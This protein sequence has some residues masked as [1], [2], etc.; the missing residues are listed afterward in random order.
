MG[1][2]KGSADRSDMRYLIVLILFMVGCG[3]TSQS[4]T[5][6]GGPYFSIT[7]AGKDSPEAC[8]KLGGGK[9]TIAWPDGLIR[10]SDEYLCNNATLN[11]SVFAVGVL[12]FERCF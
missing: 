10:E 1:F 11:C 7:V 4:T 9:K 12:G 3:P 2:D 5:S 8:Y 6:S